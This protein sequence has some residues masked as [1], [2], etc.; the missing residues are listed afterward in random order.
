[1]ID[2]GDGAVFIALHDCS[3]ARTMLARIGVVRG[4]TSRILEPLDGAVAPLRADLHHQPTHA[5]TAPA[6][7]QGMACEVGARSGSSTC[8]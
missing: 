7:P 8:D 2:A 6:I 1:V 5:D 3:R 4:V